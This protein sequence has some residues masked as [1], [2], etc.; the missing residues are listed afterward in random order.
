MLSKTLRAIVV[1]VKSHWINEILLYDTCFFK[2][3]LESRLHPK[4]RRADVSSNSSSNV[5][6]RILKLSSGPHIPVTEEELCPLQI[7]TCVSLL[8]SHWQK[9]IINWPLLCVHYQFFH[10]IH[11]LGRVK[12]FI[13]GNSDLKILNILHVSIL[14]QLSNRPKVLWIAIVDLWVEVVLLFNDLFATFSK[15]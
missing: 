13:A 5:G 15:I 1:N 11:F 3:L 10:L 12:V 9:S 7:S 6:E 8:G 14:G 2:R 4:R